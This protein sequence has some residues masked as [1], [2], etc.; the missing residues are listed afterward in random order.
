VTAPDQAQLEQFIEVAYE[1]VNAAGKIAL[2]YFRQPLTVENKLQGGAFDPVTE[3][4]KGVEQHL[5]EGLARAFPD[6]AIEGEEFGVSAGDSDYRWIIDPIDGTRAFMTGVPGWGVLLGL[7]KG[8]ENILG[9][10]H[11]PFLRET[12]IGSALGGE[13]RTE[14]AV[15]P[16]IT[17]GTTELSQACL[18]S[19]HPELFSEAEFAA[20]NRV[21]DQVKLMRYGGDCYSYCMLALGQID[22]VG[23]SGLQ[24]YDI[25]P[26]IPVIEAAGGVITNWQGGDASNG[27]QVV[28]AANAELHQQ[29]LA[30]LNN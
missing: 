25:M 27:G 10:M 5:R 22:L 8:D 16:L 9:V 24:S 21:A 13:M 14:A 1:Q 19:T 15:T 12:Y 4:D 28:A 18:Y 26:L 17:R 23:E 6:H 30:V 11:Q 7:R 29:A 2:Q 20:Y 3:A